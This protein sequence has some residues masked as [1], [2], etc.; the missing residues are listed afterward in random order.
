MAAST[1][2][3][4]IIKAQD[5]ASK[6]LSGLGGKMKSVNAVGKKM[7]VGFGIV[8]GATIALGK[9]F[10][11]AANVQ[12]RAEKQLEAVLRSTGEAAGR[13]KEQMLAMARGFQQVT[14]IGDEV[15][16]SG[17]N[18]LLTF[19][20]I[21]ED[22]FP[23]ATE[24]LLDMA[25]AMNSGATPSAEQLKSQAIQLGKALNDPVEGMN[26][27][28]RVGVKFT[29][30]QEEQ[31]KTMTKAGDI[32]GAQ[33]II[34]NELAK[35]F[36]GSA[37]AA[38]ETFEGKM[39]QLGNRLS[40]VQEKIGMAMI[41]I[42]EQLGEAIGVLIG[43]FESL[44]PGQQQMIAQVLLGVAAF[45]G[46]VTV[47]S[48]A[49]VAITAISL[50]VLAVIAVLAVL[51]V[52]IFLLIAN[53]ELLKANAQLIWDRIKLSV[54]EAAIFI[55]LKWKE[56]W[57][58]S[59]EELAAFTESSSAQL[60]EL[61]GN[62]EESLEA[63][64]QIHRDKATAQREATEDS[65]AQQRDTIDQ[66]TGEARVAA[67]AQWEKQKNAA[68]DKFGEMK[69]GTT[70]EVVAMREAATAEARK[71]TEQSAAAAA[72]MS[73]AVGAQFGEMK[74]NATN[75]VTALVSETS[76][77]METAA[78]SVAGSAFRWG[79]ALVSNLVGGINTKKGAL[80]T[81]ISGLQN[82]MSRVHQS[83]NPE[84]PAQIWGKHFVENLVVG[85][86]SAESDIEVKI[87]DI[88]GDFNGLVEGFANLNIEAGNELNKLVSSHDKAAE[89]IER[90]I[91]GIQAALSGLAISYEQDLSRMDFSLA[92]NVLRQEDLI[93]QL[94]AQ[95]E[96]AKEKAE[97][98]TIL[99]NRLQKEEEALKSFLA[100]SGN[101]EE[102]LI[103]VR[104]RAGLTDF[105]RRVEDVNKA[106]N[107]LQEDFQ[108]KKA[109]MGAEVAALTEQR[110][111]E[112][113]LFDAKI[114]KFAEVQDAFQNLERG[115]SAG[116]DR[117]DAN[118][119][120]KVSSMTTKLD[121]LKS[122]LSSVT[123]LDGAGAAPLTTVGAIAPPAAGATPGGAGQ[124]NVNL[125]FGNV[126]IAK[127]VDAN[128]FMKNV[129]NILVRSLEL[130]Q[131]G[132]Q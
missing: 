113:R 33:K 5:Q 27:L 2:V 14:T 58:A 55:Q 118:I 101:I 110:A 108:N 107:K 24:T 28:S 47:L 11:D 90:K 46:L 15:I 50:P 77:K 25:T 100:E 3:K 82:I 26:A 23:Q 54:A 128:K 72:D 116:F 123:G 17:Q 29:E 32:M 86:E 18:M 65:L 76:G 105:Q 130:R 62:V 74:T 53:W 35:E 51:G 7:A 131:V 19:T 48:L 16:L 109:A 79:S 67:T 78:T 71:L 56:A 22:V 89:T 93:K 43:W 44:T 8:A 68:I 92:E 34:L 83:F 30:E 84:V 117:M 38:A 52:A 66:L 75:E 10:V 49:A 57:G 59:A 129:E 98:T 132:S 13:N 37:R 106:K 1:D 20:N 114:A 119:G 6:T 81:A 9:S 63:I 125:T 4:I 111:E 31:I 60:D 127:E 122:K 126:N 124:P 70:K 85:I 94:T 41:P 121:N 12:L 42:L 73:V 102:E 21:G 112:D 115:L 39:Q 120:D 104:R 96:G 87:E 103:E 91:G 95:L 80:S 64:N 40:D 36:G 99:E 45:T 97:D 69:T 61:K 88:I